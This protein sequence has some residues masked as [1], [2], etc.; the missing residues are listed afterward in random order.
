MR[1]ATAFALLGLAEGG[2]AVAVYLNDPRLDG[3]RCLDGSAPR[4][5]VQRATSP[6]NSTKWYWHFQGG[7]WCDSESA[8]TS[9]AFD[10]KECMLGSSSLACFNANSNPHAPY[11]DRMDW[12]DIPACNG[13]R[14]C[15]GLM[16]DSAA[17]NPLTHDWNKV[18]M[19]Y[20]DGGSYSGNNATPTPVKWQGEDRLIY[21]RGFRNLDRA[22]QVLRSDWGLANATQV[23][24]SGDSAGGLA[25]Y[26][27]A[28]F[29]QESLPDAFVAAVP[30][31][32][33][34]VEDDSKPE[35]P[36][37]LHWIHNAM[38]STAGLDASCVEAAVKSS[39]DV[40]TACTLP[41]K[42]APHVRVPLLVMNSK[43]DPAM[44]SISTQ[45]RTKT[46]I[47]EFGQRWLAK[48]DAAVLDTPSGKT[49]R[50]GAFVT[51]CHQHCG[52][53]T[54]GQTT[55]PADFN[56]TIDGMTAPFAVQSWF[57]WNRLNRQEGN[58]LAKEA[59]FQQS[60][61]YKAAAVYPCSNC[62]EGGDGGSTALS[63]LVL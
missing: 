62:C 10:D 45:E 41:E 25:S 49:G 35:W 9:R 15:G 57:E 28:D 46:G 47:N 32:G 17:A 23:L 59:A 34:F 22:L 8:C 51:A 60:F 63:S 16:N 1:L 42:V 39:Q 30:D 43:F 27:H 2:P 13:A 5:W 53:W 37:A 50:N 55:N 6:E 14:W 20:C 19:S 48:L 56:V 18:L 40:G 33:F 26:W 24:I 58:H 52:Q 21:Y 11:A 7:G 29:F 54:Q 61:V 38:N 3:A 36:A 44:I 4:I 12:L 31:S